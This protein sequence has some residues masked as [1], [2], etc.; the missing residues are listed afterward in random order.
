[1][2]VCVNKLQYTIFTFVSDDSSFSITARVAIGVGTPLVFIILIAVVITLT[3]VVLKLK[4]SKNNLQRRLTERGY[5]CKNEVVFVSLLS[6]SIKICYFCFQCRLVEYELRA[7]QSV[8]NM[9]YQSKLLILP[10]FG[11]MVQLS[12]IQALVIYT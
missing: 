6:F 10:V 8:Q 7:G 4:R 9:N 1:M 11:L 5:D 3:T 12:T 2:C